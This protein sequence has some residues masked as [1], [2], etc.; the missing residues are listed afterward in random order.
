MVVIPTS[1]FAV[2]LVITKLNVTVLFNVVL[3]NTSLLE[4]MLAVKLA[5]LAALILVTI[6]DKTYVL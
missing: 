2:A 3:V 4:D 1:A 6:S 5:I